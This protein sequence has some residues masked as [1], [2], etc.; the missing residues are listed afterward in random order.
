MSADMFA[1]ALEGFSQAGTDFLSD[2]RRER[3]A[4]EETARLEGRRDD[5]VRRLEGRA[6]TRRAEDL[7]RDDVR[8]AED[9][10]F[11]TRAEGR[12]ETV[13]DRQTS[14]FKADAPLREE[15][16]LVAAMSKTER[17]FHDYGRDAEWAAAP[18]A[19]KR[20]FAA[21]L[22]ARDLRLDKTGGKSPTAGQE[23][24][25]ATS[26]LIGLSSD[27]MK[28][29]TSLNAQTADM[30]G[31][32]EGAEPGSGDEITNQALADHQARIR[33]QE[34]L[35]DKIT[36]QIQTGSLTTAGANVFKFKTE[37]AKASEEITT[38]SETQSNLLA[39][40]KRAGIGETAVEAGGLE[41]VPN[42]DPVLTSPTSEQVRDVEAGPV[43]V[44]EGVDLFE[45]DQR[46]GSTLRKV[47]DLEIDKVLGK[48][49]A[50]AKNRNEYYLETVEREKLTPLIHKRTAEILESYPTKDRSFISRGERVV[51][52]EYSPSQFTQ[53]A[54]RAAK[55]IAD[56][57][58]VS[59][60][61]RASQKVLPAKQRELGIARDP[62]AVQFPNQIVR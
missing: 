26:Q 45:A 12:A 31:F 58:G 20:R 34:A 35:F 18:P 52:R 14:E 9:L 16:R 30:L 56:E 50:T 8:R 54:I 36:H 44:E 17:A 6:D 28:N 2:E 40:K 24:E 32:V 57:Q 25:A 27:I 62:S 3:K 4:A 1:A 41:G 15:A 55:E 23:G 53:A 59:T 42:R 37:L 7:G 43:P 51:K 11:K 61:D 48:V 10:G 19:M 5:E 29:I 49:G 21:A 39:Q 33:T 60:R 47:I 22:Q 46:E 13:F 38:F